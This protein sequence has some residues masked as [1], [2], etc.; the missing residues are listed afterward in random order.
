M[1]ADS[2]SVVNRDKELWAIALII[3]EQKGRG[4]PVYIAE[5]IGEAA[6]EGD[7]VGIDLWRT[8]AE[9]FDKLLRRRNA[10]H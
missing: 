1:A 3:M 6:L 2:R 4:G 8:V 5:K 10:G 7:Q 9:R